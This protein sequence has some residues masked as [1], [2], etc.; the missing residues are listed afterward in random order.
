MRYQTSPADA[1]ERLYGDDARLRSDVSLID[2]R[3]ADD[4]A[5]W[6]LPGA[7][8]ADYTRQ[9]ELFDRMAPAPANA[10]KLVFVCY[11][12]VRSGRVARAAAAKGFD[13]VSIL[14]GAYAWRALGLPVI[15]DQ[16][17]PQA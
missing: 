5:A 11:A 7:V 2:V 4:Y 13:A 1:R 17:A 9:L 8:H 10:K 3:D 12:G 16:A 14:G 15:T 6:H